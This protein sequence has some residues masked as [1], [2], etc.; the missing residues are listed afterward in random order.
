MTTTIRTVVDGVEFNHDDEDHPLVAVVADD[1][2]VLWTMTWPQDRYPDKPPT[3]EVFEVDKALALLLAKE[4]VFTNT[5]WWEEAWPEEARK[6][7]AL[8]VSCNDVFA[9]GCADAENVTRSGIESLY[10]MWRTDPVHGHEVWCIV[11]RRQMPQ[12][13]VERAIRKGGAWDLDAL[14]AEHGLRPN[15]YDG[16]SGVLA[17]RKYEAYRAWAGEAALPYDARWWAG[18][19]EFAKANPGWDSPA[20]KA[21]DERL[22]AEWR[23]ANGYA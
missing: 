18:W 4:V 20:W 12:A 5:N 15:H 3:E 19:Q 10:R 6:T 1:G 9:W 23:A 8:C 7:L 13:P 16:V 22:C 14:K 17:R 2:D 11:Q 21:E